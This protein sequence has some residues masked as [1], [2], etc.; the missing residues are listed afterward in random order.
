MS[1]IIPTLF[2]LLFICSIGCDTSESTGSSNGGDS[3]TLFT[4]TT[5]DDGAEIQRGE[6]ILSNNMWGKGDVTGF[7][8]CI[9]IIELRNGIQFGWEWN[10]PDD[11]SNDVKA[12]PEI[13]YGWKPW[14]LQS[15]SP[16]LPIRLEA[17]DSVVVSF[18]LQR[19]FIYG[20]GNLAFD[21]WI[22]SSG[23]P[24]TSNIKHEIMIWL[25][26]SSF[27]P[28]GSKKGTV[29][30]DGHTYDFYKADWDWTYLAFDKTSPEVTERVN[31][32]AFLGYL[33]AQNHISA[34]EYVAS[35][36]FGNEIVSGAGET[37]IHDYTIHIE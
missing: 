11:G 1:K 30:I 34:D 29:T 12:Y 25:E 36:E 21:L 28:G 31:V 5:C 35:I 20:V 27:R 33:V 17:M 37:L 7:E 15:T 23:Q 19:S 13:I 26:R 24:N 22:T 6:F 10:W 16:E 4:R 18:R 3:D 14:S 32:G 8:Q 2:I 9:T